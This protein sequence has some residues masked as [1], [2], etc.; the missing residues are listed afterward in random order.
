[1]LFLLFSCPV[2]SAYV[3]P[4]TAAH[5][6]SLSLTIYR[7]LPKFMS[8][9]SVMP[10]SQ[11]VLWRPL[12]LLSV[13]PSIRHFSNES[14]VHIRRPKDWSVSF[15]ISPSSKYSGLISL[16]IDWF[17]LLAFQG[18]FRSLILGRCLI[19]KYMV[20]MRE[21]LEKFRNVFIMIYQYFMTL[22]FLVSRSAF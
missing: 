22:N 10:S 2:V 17:D 9:A 6:G 19:A 14:A 21:G 4:W 7:S 20:Q 5:Q 13:S 11:L 18:T 15:S 12:L 3:T 8:V 16:K 1:M